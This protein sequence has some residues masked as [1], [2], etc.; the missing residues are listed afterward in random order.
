VIRET[1][2]GREI[3]AR[4]RRRDR[5]GMRKV[6]GYINGEQ[7]FGYEGLTEEQV[8]ERTRRDVDAADADP[9]PDAYPAAW[10]VRTE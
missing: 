7:T 6:D 10:K 5:H 8:I 2:K 9:R 3:V 1:Y 4:T